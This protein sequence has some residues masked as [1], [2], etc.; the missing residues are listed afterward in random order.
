MLNTLTIDQFA[1][2]DHSEIHFKKGFNIL[3]GETGAGKSI[4][5]DAIGHI[6]GERADASLIRHGAEKADIQ[7]WFS[8][9]PPAFVQMLEDNEHLDPD[10]PDQAHLRRT[11][12]EKGS[13]VFINSQATTAAKLKEYSSQLVNIH[14]QHANQALLQSPEQRRRIDRYG[15]LDAALQAVTEAYRHWKTLEQQQQEW[16]KSREAQQERLEL[17]NYQ[18]QEFDSIAPKDNEF[19][20]LSERHSLLAAADD[21]LAKGT[22]LIELLYENEQNIS[23][24]LHYAVQ[25]AQTLA[26]EHKAY[27]ESAELIEQSHIYL[28]EARDTLN[29]QLSRIEHN[30][31]ELAALDE[32][33]T[34]LH[35][36]ARK[37]RIAPE[38]L[39]EHWETLA[40]EQTALQTTQEKGDNL[41]KAVKEAET[42]YYQA[43]ETLTAA[44]QAAAD[45]LATEALTWIRQLGM[46]KAQFQIALTPANKPSV[47]GM[48][49]V[50]FLL[51]AN[52]GQTLQPL[53][54]VASGGEL[55]R[56]SLA[57]EVACLDDNA[58][59]HTLIFDEIDA[60]IGGEVA[61]TVGRLLSKL[62]QTRQVLC[63][64]H[65]PQVAAYAAHHYRI[66]KTSDDTS[67]QTCVIPLDKKA[68]ITEIARMLGSA[69]STTSR[70]H[71]EM[72]LKERQKAIR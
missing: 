55:S 15:K 32:R 13:K 62:S 54:K 11:I 10:A 21:I 60:G 36:L 12:R 4:L 39:T 14:G 35:T 56:I 45:E 16:Q 5:I 38:A 59:P 24:H 18:L 22:Q 63:I 30:P 66:E 46:E 70:Q 58:V 52:P 71:A 40:E 57:I 44:R 31:E 26:S 19:T 53:A 28:E 72:M 27:Q 48:D 6:L 33:M 68:R 64:T 2:I 3:T 41:S 23:S 50:S 7:A 29:R 25:L 47:H 20:E 17:L 65:L 42:H 8:H 49:E 67:T 61:D 34:Q 69:D 51:C 1:I 37:H 9:I 43:A